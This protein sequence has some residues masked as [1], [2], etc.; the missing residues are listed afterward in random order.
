ME[1]ATPWDTRCNEK[2]LTFQVLSGDGADGAGAAA[3]CGG[4]GKTKQAA[5]L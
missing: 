3:H 4:A 1:I 5:P 2:K